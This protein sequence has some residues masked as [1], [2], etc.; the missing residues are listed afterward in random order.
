MPLG[1]GWDRGRRIERSDH[2]ENL[3]ALL[4]LERAAVRHLLDQPLQRLTRAEAGLPDLLS[5]ETESL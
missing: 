2:L 5:G 4:R 3:L 1:L